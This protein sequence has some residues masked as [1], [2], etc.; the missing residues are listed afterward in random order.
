[1]TPVF[2]ANM[3]SMSWHSSDTFVLASDPKPITVVTEGIQLHAFRLQ[4]QV[5]LTRVGCS[6]RSH[7]RA[8]SVLA[9]DKS[10][11]VDNVTP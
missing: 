1:M 9:V 11:D 4:P 2:R 6:R 10:Y 8:S 5:F 7:R 3:L